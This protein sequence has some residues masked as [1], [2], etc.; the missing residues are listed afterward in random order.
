MAREACGTLA[1]HLPEDE[2]AA[3]GGELTSAP[4]PAWA[5]MSPDDPS[6]GVPAANYPLT[7]NETHE[8]G[9]A[10]PSLA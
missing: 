1:A 6:A 7:T 10:C 2:I 5:K 4:A 3:T 8:G 9:G